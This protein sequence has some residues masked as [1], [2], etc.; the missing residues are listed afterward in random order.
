MPTLPA[1]TGLPDDAIDVTDVDHIELLVQLYAHT[2]SMGMGVLHDIHGGLP[3]AVAKEI[4]MELFGNLLK[5]GVAHIDW[6]AGRPIKLT[7]IRVAASETI[8]I[9]RSDLY[10]RDSYPGAFGRAL[11][12]ARRSN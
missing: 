4:M 2:K 10:D 11:A 6:V 8:H 3:R 9:S 12:A 7:W 5:D 1:T